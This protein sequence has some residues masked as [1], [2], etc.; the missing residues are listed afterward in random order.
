MFKI[1]DEFRDVPEALKVREA[2]ARFERAIEQEKRVTEQ[3]GGECILLAESYVKRRR[4]F[5]GHRMLSTPPPGNQNRW[6]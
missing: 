4:N 2:Q 5:K 3:T 6:G 1:P